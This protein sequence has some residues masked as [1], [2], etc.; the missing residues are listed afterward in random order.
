MR[1][2]LLR[3]T[4]RIVSGMLARRSGVVGWRLERDGSAVEGERAQRVAQPLV[5]RHE[6]PDLL[7][8]WATL[9]AALDA[10]CCRALV[11]SRC[12]PRRPDRIGCGSELVGRNVA[13]RRGLAGSVGGVPGCPTQIPGRRVRMAGRRA[14]LCPGDLT[15]RPR[16]P[17]VDRSTWTVVRRPGLLE[18]VQDVLRAVRRPQRETSMIVVL[19]G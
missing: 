19:E 5:V 18:V 16:T 1:S 2:T 3:E 15:A 7:G 10:A 8:E 13:H 14:R 9:P 17:E 4:R 6:I 11:F 12:R